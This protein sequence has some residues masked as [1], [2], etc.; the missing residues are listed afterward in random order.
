MAVNLTDEEKIQHYYNSTNVEMSEDRILDLYKIRS[1]EK[2]SQPLPRIIPIK[3]LNYNHLKR[4]IKEKIEETLRIKIM[5]GKRSRALTERQFIK[6]IVETCTIVKQYFSQ[7]KS[8]NRSTY[9][10]YEPNSKSFVRNIDFI[11]KICN[12]ALNYADESRVS[13]TQL[14]KNLDIALMSLDVD[15][16]NLNDDEKNGVKEINLPPK[17]VV[18]FKNG[19]YDLKHKKLL[20]NEEI[21][22]YDFLNQ[23]PFNIKSL[24]E[25]NQEKV[26]IVKNIMNTWSKNDPETEKTIKQIAFATIEG[27]GRNK[28]IILKSEGGD[29]KS[30]FQRILSNIAMEENTLNINLSDFGNDNYI[31]QIE[32]STRLIIGDDLSTRFKMQSN[33]ISNFKSIVSGEKLQVEVKFMN[34]KTIMTNAVMI[35]NTNTDVTFYENTPA[36]KARI[37]LINWPHY[38]FRKNPITDFNLDEL[39]G[40][41]NLPNNDFMEAFIAYVVETTDYFKSF[42]I[43][44][45]MQDEL[46]ASINESDQ[47]YQFFE[48]IKECGLLNCKVIPMSPLYIKYKNWLNET[49]I[50]SSPL[51]QIEFIKRIKNYLKENGYT[52]QKRKKINSLK[53][54]DFN[55]YLLAEPFDLNDKTKYRSEYINELEKRK[56][57]TILINP[58]INIYNKDIQYCQNLI[59]EKNYNELKNN[60]INVETIK[61]AIKNL[62][63]FE[64][65][66]KLLDHL[67]NTVNIS[68]EEMMQLTKNE[69]INLL[70]KF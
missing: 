30:T 22:Y 40:K 16:E 11:T 42:S 36:M 48:Y 61:I 1:D 28:Y 19:V 47:I 27:D 49:N 68:V 17:Y 59:L 6:I 32:L 12:D 34:N 9:L 4:H 29:G 57:A 51:K 25:C 69:I 63:Q 46:D 67:N 2:L 31:N 26:D 62:I 55:K 20:S 58:D 52:E 15:T 10:I 64:S 8:T 35:Q 43:S 45:Q 65:N 13:L 24:N 50:G 7:S 60:D 14:V 5:E 41:Y 66:V 54:E 23:I 37:I 44:K 70:N 38:D 33:L 3:H 56:N 18:Q 53:Q 21:K 39:T